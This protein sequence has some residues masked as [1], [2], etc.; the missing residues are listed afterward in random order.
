MFSR[1]LRPPKAGSGRD[2]AIS[3]EGF[4]VIILG[5]LERKWL[6]WFKLG[7]YGAIHTRVS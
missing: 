4:K 3:Q 5:L 6:L 2:K 7:D 1:P